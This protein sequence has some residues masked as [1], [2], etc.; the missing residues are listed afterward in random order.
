MAVAKCNI[1]V[2]SRFSLANKSA[3]NISHP[4]SRWPLDDTGRNSVNP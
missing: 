3:F 2:N 4:I 1:I